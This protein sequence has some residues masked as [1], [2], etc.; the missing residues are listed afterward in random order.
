M[1]RVRILSTRIQTKESVRSVSRTNANTHDVLCCMNADCIFPGSFWHISGALM[2]NT[3][4][5]QLYMDVL[6]T[7]SWGEK[8]LSLCGR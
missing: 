1:S 5:V 6:G 2:V 4:G 3:R 7:Y 8:R